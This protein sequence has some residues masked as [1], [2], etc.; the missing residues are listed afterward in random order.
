MIALWRGSHGASKDVGGALGDALARYEVDPP[1]ILGR[2]GTLLGAGPRDFVSTTQGV[3]SALTGW[4]DNAAEIASELG[5]DGPTG[6][7]TLHAAALAR[8][9]N[10]AERRLIG[11]YAAA[12]LLPDGTIH[13]ART[14]WD[15]PPLYYHCSE[16][17]IVASPLFRVLF[18]AGAPRDLDRERLIDDL[19]YDWHSGEQSTPWLGISL[20]PLGGIVRI[21]GGKAT[22]RVWYRPPTP[23]RNADYREEEAVVRACELLDEAAAKALDWAARPALALSGGLDSPLLA[24]ALVKALPAGQRLTT[25]TFRPDCAW[26][27]KGPPGTMGD[28]APLVKELAEALPQ[29]DPHFTEGTIPPYDW[30]ARDL[31]AAMEVLVPGLANVAM[32]HLVYARAR[33]LGCDSLLVGDF[34]NSTISDGGVPAYCEYVREGRWGQL[35]A[36]LRNRADDSRP[37]WR[38]ALALSLL[39][40]LPQRLRMMARRMV[41][42]GRADMTGVVSC[43]SPEARRQRLARRPGGAWYDFTYDRSRAETV[44]REWL[45]ADGRGKDCDLGFEQ[46]YGVR[47]RDVL[48]Y[49]PL[50][51]FC[52][53]LPTRAFAWDGVSRRLAREMGR[54]RVPEAIRTNPLHGQHNVDWHARIRREKATI[55]TALDAARDDPWLARTLDLPRLSALLDD[56]P[57]QPDFTWDEMFP[58]GLALP[59]ALLTARFIGHVEGSNAL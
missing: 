20:V 27:G 7:A 38:R 56:W 50:V 11:T 15:A 43:L 2:D 12:A 16:D 48:S 40:H 28:E 55:R 1:T 53:S 29:I 58:R 41:H 24:S 6:P 5:I 23:M 51:E 8:W 36:L 46:L 21:A 13:L 9:G 39:P 37:I 59:R 33:E 34:G 19:V 32:Y 54:G 4:I 22:C 44:A 25:I 31:Y 35:T 14:P 57:E 49:R 10:E 30:R 52:M 45:D 26:D 47:R 18:A 3:T 17:G 42:P